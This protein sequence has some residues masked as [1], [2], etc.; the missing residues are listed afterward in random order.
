MPDR[1][2]RLAFGAAIA[3]A[4]LTSTL[5]AFPQ[6]NRSGRDLAA[7]APAADRDA[8]FED[9]GG[10]EDQ[11]CYCPGDVNLD[12]KIDGAD[13]AQILGAWGT[14][15][16][17]LTGDG[18]VNGADLAIVL[19]AWGICTPPSNDLC[20]TAKYLGHLQTT[21]IPFCTIGATSS[22]PPLSDAFG[23]NIAGSNT[24]VNDIWYEFD[25]QGGLGWGI[26]LRTCDSDFD[27]KIA[28]YW[29]PYD[30]GCTGPGG[31]QLWACNDDVGTVC[32]SNPFSSE[33]YSPV[34][35]ISYY[36]IRVGGYS[37]VGEGELEIT[38]YQPGDLCIAPLYGGLTCNGSCSTSLIV[39][40]T[41][42]ND[43]PA[44]VAT[45]CGGDAD[46]ADSWIEFWVDCPGHPS[47]TPTVTVSTCN[48]TTNFDTVLTVFQGNDCSN[49]V[50]IACNDDEMDP[51]CA[52]PPYG[53][54]RESKLQFTA[55][56]GTYYMIRVAGFD[57]YGGIAQV[58]ISATCN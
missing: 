12:H 21:T 19:G 46:G 57:G 18:I 58:D 45:S 27:T 6:S 41:T 36:A 22:G 7:Q 8:R 3:C 20:N 23:C 10:F 52:L 17:D 26:R 24:I 40:T 44:L 2:P 38:R 25:V 37:G 34:D 31:L 5:V 55:V 32:A 43:D 42:S 15:S 4:A 48:D 11:P 53:Y 35:S 16:N 51:A 50:E 28:L 9:S 30:V 47:A 14:A 33:L 56:Q 1:H 39:D 54:V 29:V 49:L 13:L